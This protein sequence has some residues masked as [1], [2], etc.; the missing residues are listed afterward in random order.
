M[1]NKKLKKKLMQNRK[2]AQ[3]AGDRQKSNTGT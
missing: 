3:A 1:T 2:Y